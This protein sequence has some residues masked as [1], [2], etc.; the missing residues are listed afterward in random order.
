[1][2]IKP[3][4]GVRIFWGVAGFSLV[5]TAFAA[6][7][8]F[9]VGL[10]ISCVA[11]YL[12]VCSFGFTFGAAQTRIDGEGISERNFFLMSKKFPWGEIESGRIYSESYYYKDSVGSTE[13]RQ[14]T[15]V[16]FKNQQGKKLRILSRY[17]GPENWWHEMRRIAKEKLG[18]RFEG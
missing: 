2:I 11:L 9:P 15:L 18:E 7:S 5:I 8:A 13:T 17:V 10:P 3:D 4:L 6:L 12:A 1:M 16:E 14:R